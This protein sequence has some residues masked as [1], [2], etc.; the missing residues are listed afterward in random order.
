MKSYKMCNL[1][2]VSLSLNPKMEEY[3]RTFLEYDLE[4]ISKHLLVVGDLAG[5][6][7][8]CREL[9]L[10]P[11]QTKVC[12]N[13]KTEFKFIASRRM[14]QFPGERFAIARRLRSKRSDLILLDYQD[15]TKT[16]G[17]KKARDFFA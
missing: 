9:G 5:D 11:Y 3:I 6:C 15:F 16:L 1:V 8:N 7:Y 4:H 10:D 17:H 12:P 2:I 14:D 13:C